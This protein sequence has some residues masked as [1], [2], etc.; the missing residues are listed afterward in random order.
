MKKHIPLLLALSS[1]PLMAQADNH[2]QGF[3]P[4]RLQLGASLSH[5]VVDSPFGGGNV[6]AMGMSIFAG[7]EL[8]NDIDQV[9][10]TVEI[11]YSQTDDFFKGPHNDISGLWVAGVVEKQL[12][13]I[14]PNLFALARL[15]LDLGDDD[16]ILLG[17][18]AGF[19]L[20]PKVDIRGEYINKDAS[21]VYQASFVLN[22]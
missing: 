1:L 12:P 8:D 4:E 17:A 19:H 18:G 21:S 16:G 3:Q 14:N 11:G 10:T 5:N 20:T 6:D 15:G 2:G 22:F 13:E 7:Y 9:K